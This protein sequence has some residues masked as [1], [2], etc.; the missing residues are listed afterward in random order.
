MW[1]RASG[2]SNAFLSSNELFMTLR[3]DVFHGQWLSAPRTLVFA[4]AEALAS[5]ACEPNS[6][7]QKSYNTLCWS[8]QVYQG[9]ESANWIW[10]SSAM[11]R[12][13]TTR[14][15]LQISRFTAINRFFSYIFVY[16][17][18]SVLLVLSRP[19]SSNQNYSLFQ[20]PVPGKR[21]SH[22]VSANGPVGKDS[23]N[24]EWQSKG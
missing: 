14:D 15:L 1:A 6:D 4:S 22:P 24:L 9:S 21:P 12:G 3:S 7:V 13:L 2:R 17:E 23:Q 11:G 8:V 16:C 10:E 5:V 18:Y 20:A 19:C